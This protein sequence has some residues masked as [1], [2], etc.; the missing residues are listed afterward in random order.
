MTYEQIDTWVGS[1][2]LDVL[3]C[4]LTFCIKFQRKR[5]R[6]FKKVKTQCLQKCRRQTTRRM[7]RGPK[8]PYNRCASSFPLQHE[9]A[10]AADL[11]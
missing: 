1:S 3:W 11:I 4:A 9:K 7:D 2:P 8:K 6:D 5:S 10:S